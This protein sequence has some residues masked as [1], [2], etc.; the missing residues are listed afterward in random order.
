MGLITKTINLLGDQKVFF[1]SDPHYNH[2]NICRGTTTWNLEDHGGSN[3]VRDFDT[4]E[5]MNDKI[6]SDINNVVGRNDYLVCL[7]DW[8]FGGVNS[9]WEFRSRIHCLNVILVLGNHDEKI[10]NN[11]LLPNYPHKVGAQDVFESVFGRL[12]LF[13]KSDKKPTR[14]Y[15]CNHFPWT[16]WDQR[17]HERVHLFGHVHGNFTHP[18]RA[19]D[20]GIDNIFKI[21]GNYEPLSEYEIYDYM[22]DRVSLPLDHHNSKTN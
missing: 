4:V 1:F 21:K 15:D 18:D 19:L 5:E 6:V 2:K 13:V 7:G 12:Q 22:R 10:D 16:I 9:I 3:A 14:A 8:S 20:V 11:A 17:H